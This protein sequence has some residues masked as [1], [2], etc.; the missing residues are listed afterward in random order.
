MQAKIP[1]PTEARLNVFIMRKLG[2]SDDFL[3]DWAIFIAVGKER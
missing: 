1:Y 2:L 3:E